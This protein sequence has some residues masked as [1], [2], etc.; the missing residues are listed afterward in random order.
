MKV[1]SL[2][3]YLWWKYYSVHVKLKDLAGKDELDMT[4]KTVK[5]CDAW[6]YPDKQR[7]FSTAVWCIH[8]VI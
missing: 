5:C 2:V 6:N 4:G 7:G 3:M 1:E 8:K